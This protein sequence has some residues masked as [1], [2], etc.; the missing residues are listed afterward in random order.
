M[1]VDVAVDVCCLSWQAALNPPVAMMPSEDI[2]GET[3]CICQDQQWSF[4][5]DAL[6]EHAPALLLEGLEEFCG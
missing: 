6:P 5:E 4:T 2:F 3:V 1:E